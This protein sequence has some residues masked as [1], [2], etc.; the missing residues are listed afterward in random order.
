MLNVFRCMLKLIKSFFWEKS[1]GIFF[2]LFSF[3]KKW[4]AAAA[5]KEKKLSIFLPPTE[6]CFSFNFFF[7]G[8][9]AAR[10]FDL[11]SGGHFRRRRRRDEKDRQRNSQR[12]NR[13]RRRRRGDPQYVGQG[14]SSR[15]GSVQ[16]QRRLR[17]VRRRTHR[18]LKKPREFGRLES[19]P[20][21]GD[22]R[23]DQM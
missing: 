15:H 9:T 17:T 14:H 10:E 23:S 20:L 13:V 1:S 5:R 8:R 2:L 16:E 19:G 3:P 7:R 18:G 12:G 6:H 4:P 22:R 11:A 21:Q